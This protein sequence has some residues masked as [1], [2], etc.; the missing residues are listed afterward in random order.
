MSEPE[1]EEKEEKIFICSS[2]YDE[3]CRKA[4]GCSRGSKHKRVMMSGGKDKWCTQK[5]YDCSIVDK[6]VRCV[7]DHQST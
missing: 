7:E 6:K 1:K 5:W 3:R 4:G 2:Y